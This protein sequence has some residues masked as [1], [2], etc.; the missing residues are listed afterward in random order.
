MYLYSQIRL[1]YSLYFKYISWYILIFLLIQIIKIQV[2]HI[3]SSGWLCEILLLGFFVLYCHA[4]FFCLILS[5]VAEWN[6]CLDDS[7]SLNPCCLTWALS[8]AVLML[9]CWML[10]APPCRWTRQREASPSAKMV[11]WIWEW[12][13][14]GERFGIYIF[15]DLLALIKM[16]KQKPQ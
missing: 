1:S 11:L 14:R 16:V 12:M 13:E 4:I 5:P 15:R 6:H 9:S 10:A 2:G 3:N 8:Q 7:A